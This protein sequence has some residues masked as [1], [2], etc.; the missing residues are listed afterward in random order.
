MKLKCAHIGIFTNARIPGYIFIK[1]AWFYIV[2]HLSRK[3]TTNA[4]QYFNTVVFPVTSR[5]T[6]LQTKLQ[7]IITSRSIDLF[8]PKAANTS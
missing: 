8:N 3:T 5:V 6:G 4:A 1:I 2:I 7:Y